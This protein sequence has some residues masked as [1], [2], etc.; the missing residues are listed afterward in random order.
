MWAVEIKLVDDPDR[1]QQMKHKFETEKQADN[2]RRAA[3]GA[4]D[5]TDARV[6]EIPEVGT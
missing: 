2:I 4:S 3:L 6:V 5:C 1:W